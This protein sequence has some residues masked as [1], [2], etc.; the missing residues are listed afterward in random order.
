MEEALW[1][2]YSNDSDVD[3]VFQIVN[4]IN[5]KFSDGVSG[6]PDAP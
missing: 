5:D 3:L 4:T 1:K 2:R 6:M